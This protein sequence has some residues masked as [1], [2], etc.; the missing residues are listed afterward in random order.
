MTLATPLPTT[1]ITENV[2]ICQ[3]SWGDINSLISLIDK[4]DVVMAIG[5]VL[6]RIVHAISA[7]ISKPTIVDTYYVPEIE[8]VMLELS[9]LKHD[10]DM[11]PVFTDDL[12]V[13]LRQ[14]DFFVCALEK[15]YDFW[16]GALMATGR[17]NAKTLGKNFLVDRFIR[18]VPLGL[19]DIPPSIAQNQF[20]FKGVIPG[21]GE[22]DKVIYWGGGIWDWMDPISLM[23]ALKE[24]NQVRDDVRVVFGA[25]R[26]YDKSIV[27]EMSVSDR[28]LEWINRENWLGK[29]VFFQD[30]SPYDHRGSYLM[31]ADLGVSLSVETL[32]SR[33]AIR[34]RLLDYFWASLP[35]VLSRGDEMALALEKAGLAKLVAPG[36]VSGLAQAILLSIN[37]KDLRKVGKIQATPYVESLKWSNVVRP[38]L[39][40]LRN[41]YY[42]EDA[43]GAR[44]SM[45]ELIPLRKQWEQLR[46]ENEQLKAE[47]T[48]M[49]QRKVV[50]I[51]DFIGNK[52]NRRKS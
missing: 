52:I 7:P 29:Y 22:N 16:I 28:L 4:T 13:Y 21:I 23:E 9:S 17:I 42:A 37:D 25:L 26:H 50:R 34:T 41:P 40:Y 14:G 49:R 47:I 6:A 51:A 12:F 2:Q 46:L 48:M 1:R 33:Y 30:W 20:K 43:D 3:F 24:V 39:D 32:E 15:Q 38:L 45:K 8:Q 36:D 5:P 44:E 18:I 35:C 27:A 31:D 11:T 19:P 10:I